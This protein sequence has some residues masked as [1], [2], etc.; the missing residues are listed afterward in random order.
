MEDSEMKK[1]L[2]V[3]I[4]L[5][6]LVW[7]LSCQKKVKEEPEVEPQV[8]KVEEE[9]QVDTAQVEVAP[10]DTT[11]KDTTTMIPIQG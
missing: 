4:V 6:L 5:S 3:L 1:F 11:C 10:M 9:V 2:L 8:E 7:G